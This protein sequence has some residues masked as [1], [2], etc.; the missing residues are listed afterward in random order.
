MFLCI[1]FFLVVALFTIYDINYNDLA[2]HIP[3]SCEVISRSYDEEI[4]R[5]SRHSSSYVRYR[6]WWAV[7]YWVDENAT[8][9]TNASI[10]FRRYRTIA[11]AENILSQYEV[12]DYLHS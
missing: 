6:P 12:N 3:N 11:E 5:G 1:W 7:R 8:E 10:G 4:C 2:I 9:Y